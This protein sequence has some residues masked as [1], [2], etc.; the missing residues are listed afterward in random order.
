ML[1]ACGHSPFA[2]AIAPSSFWKCAMPCVSLSCSVSRF[3][4][5]PMSPS[6]RSRSSFVR[7]IQL[8][9]EGRVASE[10][11]RAYDAAAPSMPYGC[12]PAVG[13]GHP[14]L[15]DRLRM[16]GGYLGRT[17]GSRCCEPG[18]N[19]SGKPSEHGIFCCSDGESLAPTPLWLI[20]RCFPMHRS[21]HGQTNGA[22]SF[23]TRNASS[24]SSLVYSRLHS[25]SQQRKLVILHKSIFFT[26]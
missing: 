22:A 15:H 9:R 20:T 10:S 6:R 26:L 3:W 16:I 18:G 24:R 7:S 19:A 1:C 12:C 14:C 2:L 23:C 21:G 5:A 25:I 8:H 4:K 17:Y 11:G 13:P